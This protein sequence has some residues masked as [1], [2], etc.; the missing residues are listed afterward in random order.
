MKLFDLDPQHFSLW[1]EL[2]CLNLDL[3][4][5]E[6]TVDPDQMTSHESIWSGSTGF[7]SLCE[8]TCLEL[9]CLNQDSSFFE[10]T[11]DPDQMASHEAIWSGPTGFSTLIENT[12]PRTWMPKPGFILFWKQCRSRI[13]WFLMKPSDLHPQGF[14]FEWKYILRTWMH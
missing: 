2:E 7:S 3:S 10:N 13:R 11:V 5:F 14:L 1:L 9:E 6:N 12:L 8:N 4:Y